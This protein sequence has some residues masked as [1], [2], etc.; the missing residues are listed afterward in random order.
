MWRRS[1]LSREVLL[2]TLFAG[3]ATAYSAA[4]RFG[5]PASA[6]LG[7]LTALF[8]I[9]GVTASA[10]IY[11]V[12]ARPAWNSRYTVA[13]FF[14]A[15]VILGSLFLSALGFPLTAFAVAGAVAQLLNQGLKFLWMIRS[16]EFELQGSA[17]LLS[18]DLQNLFL[19]RFGLLVAG[20]VVLPLVGYSLVGVALALAG[21]L[22][23]RYLFFVRV[24]P[25]DMA[26][27][28]FW[29]PS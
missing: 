1:W 13:E 10:F 27:R 28:C 2:F 5:L 6:A 12:P 4:L 14:L 25:R 20:G 7:A 16:D 3:W 9:G 8:G 22:V 11:L 15:A 24:V 26:A 17:R 21:G 18:A 23:G 29:N 19:A